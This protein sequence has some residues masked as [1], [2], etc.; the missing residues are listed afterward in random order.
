MS[1]TNQSQ[2]SFIHQLLTRLVNRPGRV[3]IGMALLTVALVAGGISLAPTG[4]ASFSPGGEVFETAEVVEQTFRPSTTEL[5]FISEDEGADALDRETLAE[6]RRNSEALRADG[7]LTPGFSTYFDQDLRRNVVGFYTV[8]DAVDEE[9]R[10]T[11]VSS[12]LEGASDDQV[13]IALSAV[14]SEDRP[15]VVFRDLLSQFATSESRTVGGE[16]ITLWSSPAFLSTVRVDHVAFPVALES[17]SD[18]GSRTLA[19]RQAIEEARDPKIEQWGRD[20]Q[21]TLRG[22][23]QSFGLWGIAIDNG[24]TGDESFTSTVPFLLGAFVLIVLLV[25]SLLRSYWAAAL[26]GAGLGV[27]L[28]WARMLNNI[29]GFEE[30]IILDVIVPIATISF[31]VDFFIHAV[32]RVREELATGVKHRSAYAIGIA[33]VGGALVLALSTASI[34]FASNATSSVDAV[35]QFGFGAAISLTSAF[36]VLG[37]LA[38]MFLL[39]IEEAVTTG[40]GGAKSRVARGVSGVK[41]VGAALLAGVMLLSIVAVPSVGAASVVL[42]SALFLGLPVWISRRRVRGSEVEVTPDVNT[43][44]QSSVL[45]GTLVTGIAR[46]R[47]A[48]LGVIA[49][50]T[51]GAGFAAVGVENRTRPE[52]FFPR[53]SDFIVGIDKLVEHTSAASAGDV[54]VYVEGD[55]AD[56]RTLTAAA[57][58]NDAIDRDGG[59]LF[60][61]NPDGTLAA[62]ASAL[63]IASAAIAIDFARETIGEAT[64]ISLT[65]TN[66]DGFPDTT[67]QVES[68]FAYVTEQ[69]LRSDSST[70]AFTADEVRTV[71]QGESGSWATVLRY[72]FQGFAER[73]RVAA[74]QEAVESSMVELRAT[75]AASG[76]TLQALVSGDVV[77]EQVSLDSVT[78]T[79]VISVPLAMVLC[80]AVAALVMRSLRMAAV[81]V[82]P[83]ALV[84]VWLLGF[85]AI[86]N[87]DI[88]VITATIAAISIGVG[89]DFSIH[90]TMR[91]RTELASGLSRLEAVRSAAGDG[92][93]ARAL[94]FDQHHRIRPAGARP[95][96]PLRRIRSLDRGDGRLLAAGLADHA[97]VAAL[98]SEP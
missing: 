42:Y 7:E 82:I 12:G 65:D 1:A 68:V 89:I 86:F 88:N 25:G 91:F 5:L 40:A 67:A 24:L 90:F 23:Q 52:D 93:G 50:V 32:G 66:G 26:T 2:P 31:G 92:H 29:V 28:L 87:Y 81:S 27:T 60:A 3:V 62:S 75:T 15:T 76:L 79:M 19:Q 73:G 4:E 97:A 85:M 80:L 36:V 57:I 34:A 49:L 13:K 14:L 30:S 59:D 58:A 35:T 53:N 45:A 18:A 21:T 63:D 61:R 55:L 74:A 69:G 22:E 54:Y 56:P 39:R 94:R 20:T 96:A 8:A 41:L 33:A 47:Y 38:P 72:P 10:A 37:I 16:S 71:L 44:G 77:A 17:E 84:V 6:F 70:F 98:P 83:I 64:G 9:L 78:D 46:M 95:D 51:V 11:G 48:A 43:T